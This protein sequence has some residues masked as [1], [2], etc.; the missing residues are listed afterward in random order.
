MRKREGGGLDGTE[1]EGSKGGGRLSK[2]R[3]RDICPFWN[4]AKLKP[5]GH[6]PTTRPSILPPVILPSCPLS[7]V[8]NE[9]SSFSRLASMAL[10]PIPRIIKNDD[11]LLF[12]FVRLIGRI[13]GSKRVL[14]VSIDT[15]EF[16][17]VNFI[18][19]WND[20]IKTL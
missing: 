17:S 14:F 8:I 16:Q 7:S 3:I 6:L 10:K 4:G 5:A 1:E 2:G 15:L 20:F 18:S 11:A 9:G 19:I 13:L 12:L